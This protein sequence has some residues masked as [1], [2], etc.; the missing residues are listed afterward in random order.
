MLGSHQ[1]RNAVTALAAIEM[2]RTQKHI[3]LDS[4]KLK[5]GM[6]RVRLPARFEIYSKDPLVI[7]DGAHNVEGAAALTATLKDLLPSKKILFLTSILEDKD[8]AGILAKLAE[9]AA[10]MVVTKSTN[11]RALPPGEL[12]DMV[13]GGIA[14][15]EEADPREAYKL[16]LAK[17]AG[18]DAL[19]V[20][21]SLYLAIDIMLK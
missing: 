9:C 15:Y 8:A 3:T 4:Q 12:R 21:G 7:I 6:R 1:V 17:L 5:E 11:E 14:V 18:Y 13:P 16:A 20:C 19:V 2:L 10:G